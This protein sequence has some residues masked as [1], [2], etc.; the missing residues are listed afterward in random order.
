MEWWVASGVLIALVLIALVVRHPLRAWGQEVQLER[1]RELF[2]LQRERL[3]AKFLDAAAA[4]GKPRGLRWLNIDWET[5]LAF[6]R[7][8]TMGQLAAL[9]GITIQFEA[10]EGGDMEGVAAVSNLRNACAVFHF[11]RGHWF[12]LGKTIFNLNP[13]E[14]LVRF[15][16]QYERVGSS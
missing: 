2:K 6:A 1:A 15:Q 3:E 13:S 9:V 16:Q 4:S 12:T 10:I 7:D 14:A 11:E 5:E 8:R